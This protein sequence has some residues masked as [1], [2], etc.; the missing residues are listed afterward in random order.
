VGGK[1]EPDEES[2]HAA[3]R[4]LWE[5]TSITKADIELSR[6]MDFTYYNYDIKIEVFVGRLNRSMKVYGDENQLIWLDME[7]DFFDMAKFAGEGNIGH[8]MEHIK[9]SKASLLQLPQ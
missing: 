2:F 4:E 8:I 3:Y 7:Q 1:I 6:F 5:E 9:L